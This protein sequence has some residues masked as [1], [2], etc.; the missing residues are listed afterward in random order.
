[1]KDCAPEDPAI[2]EQRERDYR[3]L[4]AKDEIMRALE[5]KKQE[6]KQQQRQELQ[7]FYKTPIGRLMR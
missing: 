2:T 3:T 1:V 6:A 5:A 7:Q 4:R